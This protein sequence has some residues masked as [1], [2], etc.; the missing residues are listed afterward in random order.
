[1]EKVQQELTIAERAALSARAQADTAARSGVNDPTIF[2]RAGAASATAKAKKEQLA[3][4]EAKK[5]TREATARDL[6]RQI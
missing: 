3:R 6:R 5:N 2:E 4:Y 1:V